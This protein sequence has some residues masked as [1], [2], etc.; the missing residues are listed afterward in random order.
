MMRAEV[1][2]RA[3]KQLYARLLKRCEVPFTDK[4]SEVMANVL[5]LATSRYSSGMQFNCLENQLEKPLEFLA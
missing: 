3:L 1:K 4:H 5:T 2:L